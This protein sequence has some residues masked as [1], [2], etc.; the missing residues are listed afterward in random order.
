LPELASFAKT[1]FIVARQLLESTP[2]EISSR[3]GIS[4]GRITR[5]Q[6]LARRIIL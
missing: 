6:D 5:L 4:P 2:N 1:G 3:T